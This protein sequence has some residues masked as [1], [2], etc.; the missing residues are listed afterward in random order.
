MTKYSFMNVSLNQ[1]FFEFQMYKTLNLVWIY[2][3]D[4]IKLIN[5]YLISL[6]SHSAKHIKLIT[7]D[8]YKS[9]YIDVKDIIVF[10]IIHIK[11]YYNK[12]HQSCFFNVNNVINLQLHC[13]YILFS[14]ISQNKKLKQQFVN[15][16][17]IVE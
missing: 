9:V 16:L 1:I 15:S 13:R 12:T 17:Y 14:F 3:S 6:K 7:I 10:V 5:T 11:M 2:E 4:V 8:Q